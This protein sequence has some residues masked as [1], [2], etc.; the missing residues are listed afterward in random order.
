MEEL[1][2]FIKRDFPGL[3]TLIDSRSLLIAVNQE[4]ARNDTIVTDGDE[5]GFLPPFSGG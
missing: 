4:F 3:S 5:V 2:S 1:K